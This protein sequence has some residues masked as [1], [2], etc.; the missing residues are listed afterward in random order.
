MNVGAGSIMVRI[1]PDEIRGRATSIAFLLASGANSVGALAAGFLLT[2]Y[3]TTNT[4]LGVS[5]AMF[6]V[7]LI[8]AVTPSIRHPDIPLN[9]EEGAGST[10]EAEDDPDAERTAEADDAE[11][12][13]DDVPLAPETVAANGSHVLSTADRGSDLTDPQVP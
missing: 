1:M 13:D 5:A 2:S 4:V 8:S 12:Q 6:A 3:T 9:E 7:T 11:S 10:A